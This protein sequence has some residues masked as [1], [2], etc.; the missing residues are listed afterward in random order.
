MEHQSSRRAPRHGVVR[1]EAT[2][3]EPD[4]SSGSSCLG[5]S[6][7]CGV[8]RDQAIV[9]AKSKE[10]PERGEIGL[11]GGGTEPT[12]VQPAV[13]LLRGQMIRMPV[14]PQ[15]DGLLER[16]SQ[17]L[18]RAL[19]CVVLFVEALG[20]L[21]EGKRGI[22]GDPSTLLLERLFEKPASVSLASDDRCETAPPISTSTVSP[23]AA[24]AA[25]VTL[26]PAE[27]HGCSWERWV[28]S[29]GKW[30]AAGPAPKPRCR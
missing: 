27:L 10:L 17:L 14:A 26:N 3:C 20:Q 9:H 25:A 11:P 19:T 8:A 30:G 12:P 5:A 6:A 22:D 21:C 15:P 23:D 13:D 16:V 18:G 1:G 2:R 28:G 29:G 4:C 24:P 7:L